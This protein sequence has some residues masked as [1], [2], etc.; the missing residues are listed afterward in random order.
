MLR[1]LQAPPEDS[2]AG[3]LTVEELSPDCYEIFYIPS[4]E[5]L[6]YASAISEVVEQRAKLISVDGQKNLLSVYP[7]KTRASSLSHILEPKYPQI[8]RITLEHSQL[9]ETAID[10]IKEVSETGADG[11]ED[12]ETLTLE[13]AVT[14]ALEELP[15]C[16][17]K[18]YDF[19]LGLTQAYRFIV[20]AVEDLSDCTEIVFS[21]LH[22][23]GI[24]EE[25]QAFY[26]STEDLS[27]LRK[28]IDRINNN[29]QTA[30]RSMND[31]TTRNFL[32]EKIGEPTIAVKVGRSH[33]R[34]RFT[35]LLSEGEDPLSSDEQEIVL[36]LI[37]KNTRAISRA[38]PEQLATLQRDM[39]FVELDRLIECYEA[40]SKKKLR[41]DKWQAFLNENPFILN[42]AFGYPVIK[43]GSQV[44]VGGRKLSGAGDKVADFLVK[45][46]MTNNAAIVE[47]KKP[48][49]KLLNDK[50]YR[51]D[52]YTPSRELAGSVNQA[53]DQKSH[54][55]QEIAQL[56]KNSE[57]HELESFSVHCCLIIGTMP[58]G[59]HQR[60]SFELFRGNS[61]DVHIVTF[62]EL[63]EKL[64]QLR[65]FLTPPTGQGES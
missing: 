59:N 63:L 19:G 1:A 34:Q 33:L 27:S 32:A 36:N 56:T 6:A 51:A 65:E 18:S 58:S 41:E 42:L 44:S 49:T 29:S 40:M 28:T 45:N 3:T 4:E 13:R 35:T 2:S 57:E 55:E 31:G 60:K 20:H 62:D 5:R 9:T 8:Q 11:E 38:L 24:D 23:T 39:Q 25:N 50:A 17:V 46:S 30:A 14:F 61:K 7:I 54:F 43:V 53:L 37:T 12:D 26:I 16:F 52:V 21:E 15:S 10:L 64:K 47:I 48:N 22:Q